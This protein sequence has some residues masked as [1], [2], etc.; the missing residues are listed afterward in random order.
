M[1]PTGPTDGPAGAHARDVAG[2]T[3]TIVG[4]ANARTGC[5]REGSNFRWLQDQRL[6]RHL[7]QVVDQLAR[8]GS[9]GGRATTAR[10]RC[11]RP[12]GG[13]GVGA[14]R[15]ADVHLPARGGSIAG[16]ST[17]RRTQCGA[18]GRGRDGEQRQRLG[19]VGRPRRAHRS[20]AVAAE[21]GRARQPSVR[22]FPWP[23][24]RSTSLAPARPVRISHVSS[25]GWTVP[26]AAA[27]TM[28]A[29]S[30][31]RPTPAEAIAPPDRRWTTPAT[32][33]LDE[34]TEPARRH[35]GRPARSRRD[36]ARRR[37]RRLDHAAGG[38][39]PRPARRTPQLGAGRHRVGRDRLAD[40]VPQAAARRVGRAHRRGRRPVETELPEQGRA[41]GARVLP[42]QVTSSWSWPSH[43]PIDHSRFAASS[44]PGARLGITP[45]GTRR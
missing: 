36:G 13:L 12:A 22:T 5:E 19:P 2:R 25:G 10:G 33:Q 39:R 3:P 11:A 21:L 42:E 40:V 4:S 30:R 41:A 16:A 43:E 23:C 27:P 9:T 17:A 32:R 20:A 35:A 24:G 14:H 45:T 1:D 34:L 28:S 7:G 37:P 8:G 6:V 18:L 44:V 29:T 26:T 31:R 15:V 38:H